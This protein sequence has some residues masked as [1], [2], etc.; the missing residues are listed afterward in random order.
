MSE[1]SSGAFY[2][3][4]L[5]NADIIILIARARARAFDYSTLSMTLFLID[6]RRRF[7]PPENQN[8]FHPSCNKILLL[9]NSGTR[10][11]VRARAHIR[12]NQT[13]NFHVEFR[14]DLEFRS[15]FISPRRR[16]PSTRML[17]CST[18]KKR[19]TKDGR[20][21]GRRANG[22][23]ATTSSALLN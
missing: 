8:S 15:T 5:Y 4:A 6:S 14:R 22:S 9:S 2:C 7:P 10:T 20:R 18:R 23:G 21:A 11:R 16:Q 17:K 19:R 1:K 12:K 3:P 13:Y